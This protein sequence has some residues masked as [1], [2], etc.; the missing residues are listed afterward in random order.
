MTKIKQSNGTESNRGCRKADVTNSPPSRK[1][2]LNSQIKI[3]ILLIR[4]PDNKISPLRHLSQ[5]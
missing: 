3:S 1:S 2:S 5:I 4:F